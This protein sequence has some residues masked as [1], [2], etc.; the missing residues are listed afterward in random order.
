MILA[1]QAQG[2][3][4]VTIEGLSN[5]DELHPVQEA[6]IE[7]DAMQC[8]FCT[9]GFVMSMAAVYRDN[10]SAS[11]EELKEGI[12]GHICRCGTYSQIFKA[13]ELAQSRLGGK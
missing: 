6:F 10:P 2:K 11:L 7:A 8:G 4:I 9:P 13:A 12:A 5:G 3:E 1:V